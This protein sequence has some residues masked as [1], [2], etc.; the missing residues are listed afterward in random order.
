MADGSKFDLDYIT[1]RIIGITFHY[2]C[3]EQMYQHNLHSIMQMLQSKHADRYMVINLSEHNDDL[4][5]MNY[6]VVDLGW[7]ER[8]APSL[9]LLC[10][11][12]KNM[13]NWL[14]AHSENV[15][16]LHC[17]G[18][19]DR[20]GVVISSYIQLSNVSTRYYSTI[21]IHCVC[22]CFRYVQV[23]GRLLTHQIRLN[24]SP[25]FIHC[26]NIH[27]I[28]D[29]HPTGDK[30]QVAVGQTDRVCFA[31]EPPQ[32]LKGDFMIVCYHKNDSMRTHE[33]VF[34]VQFHTGTLC[35]DQLSL[36]KEDLD[37]ANKGTQSSFGQIFALN[38]S[39]S[40]LKIGI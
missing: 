17:K 35:G 24:S 14:R 4:S 2:S 7:L 29:F 10:S 26:I 11:V 40:F 19:K 1:E 20:V 27:P 38:V 23:F 6:R 32:M 39:Q 21:H 25:L 31:L 36:Q 13:D 30:N 22:G 33:T 9:H 15:L 28:P 37:Y 18:S 16:L 5:R 3:T 34:G 12:C 8:Q